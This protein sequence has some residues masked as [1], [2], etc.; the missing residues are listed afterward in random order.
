MLAGFKTGPN[1][2]EEGKKIVTEEGASMCEVWYRVD[3]ADE[4]TEML[5]WLSDHDVQVGLHHWG[6]IDGKYKTNLATSYE[7]VWRATIEQMKQTIDSA[8]AV[9]AA[10]V[11]VHPGAASVE[12]INLDTKEQHMI[13]DHKTSPEESAALFL[14]HAKE[15]HEYASSKDVLLTVETLL[16]VEMETVGVREPTY[17]PSIVSLETMKAFSEQGGY[18]ANDITHTMAF[19]HAKLQ[20]EDVWSEL[21]EFSLAVAPQT[22]LLHIN[23]VVPPFN[24]TDSHNGVLDDDWEAGAIPSK[25]QLLEFLRIFAGRDDVFVV[26]EPEKD[27]TGNYRALHDLVN[28]I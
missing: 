17:D 15:V 13:D 4:Y 5:S 1:N 14:E 3:R 25:D 27:M 2:W 18:V 28:S 9:G 6:V 26:P 10:Y 23:T 16:G 21:M 7:P 8:A 20:R 11:N 19:L 24:G 12:V 22:R